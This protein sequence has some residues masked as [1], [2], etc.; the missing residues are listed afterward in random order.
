MHKFYIEFLIYLSLLS[1]NRLSL[2]IYIYY[3]IITGSFDNTVKVWDVRNGR[4][5]HTL[6]GHQGE[7]S[8]CQFTY[9]SDICVSGT[10]HYCSVYATSD[11]K[12]VNNFDQHIYY[13]GN[14]S[15][16]F[17]SFAFS[18]TFCHRHILYKCFFSKLI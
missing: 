3:Q 1:Y 18:W 13:H 7:I 5:I 4:C 15:S 9:S 2:Y 12:N 6:S 11:H 8:S 17:S 14:I 16:S 10:E